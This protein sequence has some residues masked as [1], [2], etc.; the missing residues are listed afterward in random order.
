MYAFILSYL[1]YAARTFFRHTHGTRTKAEDDN[2]MLGIFGGM[3]SMGLVLMQVANI[4]ANICLRRRQNIAAALA[5]SFSVVSAAASLLALLPAPE[6]AAYPLD[7]SCNTE[8]QFH[9]FRVIPFFYLMLPCRFRLIM[10]M[11]SPD[12]PRFTEL[13]YYSLFLQVLT[14]SFE[15]IYRA[16][17]GSTNVGRSRTNASLEVKHSTWVL[18]AFIY[19]VAALTIAAAYQRRRRR[20]DSLT[21]AL[22]YAITVFLLSQGIAGLFPYAYQ[23]IADKNV[24]IPVG[25]WVF[26]LATIIPCAIAIGARAVFYRWLVRRK[27]EHAAS[28]ESLEAGCI[29][30]THGDIPHVQSL[31][32]DAHYPDAFV[33]LTGADSTCLLRDR[34]YADHE[35]G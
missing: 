17:F 21:L 12:L 4:D 16:A 11:E 27:F 28:A 34:A 6:N 24:V 26:S 32:S 3:Q 29:T 5:V 18:L 31:T 23:A 2:I 14:Q 10:A 19:L 22:G 30:S 1:V 9:W 7:I 15:N 35:E 13:F 8:T 20:G 33:L 25:T